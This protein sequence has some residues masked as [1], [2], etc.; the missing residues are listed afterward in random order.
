[1]K[2]DTNKLEKIIKNF[3]GKKILVVGDLMLDEYLVGKTTRL[4][5]EAPVPIVEIEKIN[6]VPGGAANAANNVKSLGDETILVGIIG[7]DN[8]GQTLIKLLKKQGIKTTGVFKDPERP[9]TLKVASSHMD[10]KLSGL[11]KKAT[12]QYQK[13]L[14]ERF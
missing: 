2:I 9:T 6:Y 4:S 3:T 13:E 12:N 8:N 14:R 11:I 7:N 1:M 5:P 10:N